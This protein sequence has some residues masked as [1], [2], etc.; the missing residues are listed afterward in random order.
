[1]ILSKLN[2]LEKVEVSQK[3][4]KDE[5]EN[6]LKQFSSEDVLSRL[7]ELYVPGNKHYEELK[8]RIIYKKL[9]DSFFE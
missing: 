2:E 5:I 1:L 9:I 7:K 4:M 6:I 3:D 8:I